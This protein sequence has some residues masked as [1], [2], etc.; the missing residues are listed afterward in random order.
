MAGNPH[1]SEAMRSKARQLIEQPSSSAS[2]A[3][4]AGTADPESSLESLNGKALVPATAILSGHPSARGIQVF[5][6]AL[7]GMYG[8]DGTI[9]GM[10]ELLGIPFVGSGTLASALAMDKAMAKKIFFADGLPTPRGHLVERNTFLAHPEQAMAPLLP[11]LPVVVKPLR[12]GSSIGIV[13]VNEQAEL[14]SALRTAFEYDDRVLVEQRIMGREL[15]VGVI[16]VESLQALPPIEIVPKRSFFDYQAKYDAAL[17]DEICPAQI[18]E[19]ITAEAQ[20]LAIRAHQALG[21][22]GL[23]RTD[24]IWGTDGL[25]ILEVNTLPGLTENSLIPKAARAAGIAFPELLDRL[26]QDALK[27]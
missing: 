7:H 5:F 18:P 17:A 20:A 9:Q 3:L 19:H 22:R 24:F 25:T 15:T 2:D 4:P 6:L 12:Q 16:G 10:L 26:L 23:S 14:A 1:L 8:E 13:M 27:A 11:L 21:C